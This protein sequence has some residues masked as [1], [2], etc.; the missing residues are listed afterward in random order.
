MGRRW[1]ANVAVICDRD[2]DVSFASCGGHTSSSSSLTSPVL[3][4]TW[5]MESSTG[6]YRYLR[7][8]WKVVLRG[9]KQMS[10]CCGHEGETTPA[11]CRYWWQLVREPRQRSEVVNGEAVVELCFMSGST[12]VTP[13]CS[14][15]LMRRCGV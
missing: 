12:A 13:R 7:C 6:K 9:G 4:L 1:A 2:T 14:N 3:A 10:S 15:V 11:P 5:S 8:L